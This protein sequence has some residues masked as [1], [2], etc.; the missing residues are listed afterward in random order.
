MY[1]EE[2]REQHVLGLQKDLRMIHAKNGDTQPH[3]SGIYDDHTEQAV[4]AFQLRYKLP[5][6][7]KADLTTWDRIVHESNLIRNRNAAPLAV[8]IFPHAALIVSPGDEGRFVYILQ[9]MLNG[10]HREF[11][12]LLPLQYTGIYDI[13]TERVTKSLQRAAG[14]P[15]TGRI[16]AGTWDMLARLYSHITQR[17]D[18]ILI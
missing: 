2:Q 14:L 17:S 7:G 4:R 15:Q 16:D 6:T 10:L 18:S 11:P 1:T 8:R 9:A 12:H 3:I 5:V 13:P